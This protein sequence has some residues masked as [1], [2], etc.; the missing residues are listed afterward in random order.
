MPGTVDPF[1][2]QGRSAYEQCRWWSQK[3]V[4][5]ART[6]KE[7]LEK[8]CHRLRPTG[9]FSAEEIQPVAKMMSASGDVRYT[10]YTVTISTVGYVDGEIYQNDLVEYQGKIWRVENTSFTPQWNRS[11]F[12]RTNGSG[13]KVLVLVG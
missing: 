5:D 7:R 8:V 4:L 2:G 10:R 13:A 12:S 3:A 6:G 9:T 1:D 11:Q